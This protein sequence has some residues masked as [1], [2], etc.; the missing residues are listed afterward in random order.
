MWCYN[1]YQGQ[2]KWNC[3]QQ[4]CVFCWPKK[5]FFFTIALIF[6]LFCCFLLERVLNLIIILLSP[7]IFI[8]YIFL[9]AIILSLVFIFWSWE[10]IF[11]KR[12]WHVDIL[13]LLLIFHFLFLASYITSF[14]WCVSCRMNKI[15]KKYIKSKIKVYIFLNHFCYFYQITVWS[16]CPYTIYIDLWMNLYKSLVTGQIIS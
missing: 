10:F 11:N 15:L 13:K 2:T 5:L 6:P 12:F 16:H 3:C 1:N 7:V 9:V 14:S 4:F 8:I